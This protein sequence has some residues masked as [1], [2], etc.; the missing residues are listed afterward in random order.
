MGYPSRKQSLRDL[1]KQI[2]ADIQQHQQGSEG[3]IFMVT[4]SLHVSLPPP[5]L[6][7]CS[8]DHI[9]LCRGG[10]LW[11]IIQGDPD[12]KIRCDMRAARHSL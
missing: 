3:A 5:V 9:S 11:R 12:C 2:G 8:P 7:Q 4:H 1:A 10:I 6:E